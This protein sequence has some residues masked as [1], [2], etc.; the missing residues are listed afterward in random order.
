MKKHFTAAAALALALALPMS[1]FAAPSPVGQSATVNGVTMTAQA[2]Q[3]NIITVEPTDQNAKNVKLADGEVVLASFEV[4]GEASDIDLTF[5]VGTQYA[6]ARA[7]V[8]VEHNDGTTEVLEAVVAADGTV[9]VHVDKLSIFTIVVDKNSVPA[10]GTAGATN[11]DNGAK[12]PQTGVNETLAAAATG[13]ALVAAAGC[14][15]A[16]VS[17]TRKAN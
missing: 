4:T 5:F 7:R 2:G 13:V 9:T 16:I 11:F 6:G 8:F 14:G 12:S 1:A 3:G 15:V 17:R 10:A